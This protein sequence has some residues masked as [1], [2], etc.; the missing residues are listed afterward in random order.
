[1]SSSAL[2]GGTGII[3]F[4][5]GLLGTFSLPHLLKKIVCINVM[6]SGVF[7]VLAAVGNKDV[8]ATN[9]PVPQAMILTGIVVAMAS[10]V[11]ALA[12]ARQ[13]AHRSGFWLLPED[14]E[15]L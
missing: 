13:I 4:L 14:R 6:G 7:L 12:L 11:F 8:G 5:V 1:L 2:F 15:K 9:D 10:S 3:I